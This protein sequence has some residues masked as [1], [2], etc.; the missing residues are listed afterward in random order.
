MIIIIGISDNPLRRRIMTSPT[1]T[2][3]SQALE[4]CQEETNP[5]KN[6][7][8]IGRPIESISNNVSFDRRVKEACAISGQMRPSF[9]RLFLELPTDD[10]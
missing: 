5:R 4:H 2:T 10:A 8:V 1:T 3:T 7:K 9:Q 6:K